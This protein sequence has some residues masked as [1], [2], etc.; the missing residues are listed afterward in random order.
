MH[1]DTIWKDSHRTFSRVIQNCIN[2]WWATAVHIDSIFWPKQDFAIRIKRL[3][4][5]RLLVTFAPWKL[6]QNMVLMVFTPGKLSSLFLICL[7][8]CLSKFLNIN[9]L[10][11]II[12]ICSRVKIVFE[13]PSILPSNLLEACSLRS[14]WPQNYSFSK[15]EC[16]VNDQLSYM[17]NGQFIIE[18]L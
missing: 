6:N 13:I 10:N 14:F 9:R 16:L 11:H 15:S 12:I 1:G 8:S 3:L 2:V 7:L 17:R 5:C 4:K 18:G